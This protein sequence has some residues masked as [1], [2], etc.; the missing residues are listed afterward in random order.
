MATGDASDFKTVSTKP[1]ATL[2][3]TETSVQGLPSPSGTPTSNRLSM[4]SLF[5]G[6]SAPRENKTELRD[7]IRGE[8]YDPEDEAN[9]LC[10]CF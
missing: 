4:R 6:N 3:P 7:Q 9:V 1:G 5:G 8:M 10:S 2:V